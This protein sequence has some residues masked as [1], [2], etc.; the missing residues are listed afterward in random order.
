MPCT[1]IVEAIGQAAS[2]LFTKTTGAGTG[3]GEFLVLGSIHKMNFLKP[4]ISG[5]RMEINVTVSK[6]LGDFA[7][8][9]AVV[10]VD[11]TEVAKGMLGF[12]KRAL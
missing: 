7:I 2:I 4:V 5:D 8:V 10:T 9:E 3:S 6:F 1:L 11:R 12:A